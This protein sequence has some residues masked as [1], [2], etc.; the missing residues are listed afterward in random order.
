MYFHKV[1]RTCTLILIS[2]IAP[3]QSFFTR[4]NSKSPIERNSAVRGSVTLHFSRLRFHN[5]DFTDDRTPILQ[6]RSIGP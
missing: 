6:P 5:L 4:A 2:A 1:D 3:Y